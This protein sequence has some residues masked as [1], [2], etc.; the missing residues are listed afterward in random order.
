MKRCPY[1]AEEIQD[2]A[3]KCRYCGSDLTDA[4]PQGTGRAPS[5]ASDERPVTL[6]YIGPRY[7]L[8][9]G[10]GF[11]GIW[12]ARAP[13]PPAYRF[14]PTDEGWGEAWARFRELEPTGAPVSMGA[15]GGPSGSW[16]GPGA[17]APGALP[18]TAPKTN[19]SAVASL[20]LGIV[21][22]VLGFFPFFG[23]ILGILAI[24]FA[25]LGFRRA[26]ATGTGRGFAIAG[27]VLGIIASVFGL[28][29]VAV[30]RE[31]SD[32][33]GDIQKQLEELESLAP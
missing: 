15:V 13:G 23:L 29:L 12:D 2:E 8:G 27:L 26:E 19:G 10:A 31:V 22:V 16:S 21:G 11:H 1:C 24:V 33:V 30:F 7:G 4:S 5:E 9:S 28:L 20:V 32:Q 18:T 14:P 25:Y 6:S 17:T 3:V